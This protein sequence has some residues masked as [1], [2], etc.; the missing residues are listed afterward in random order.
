ML[1]LKYMVPITYLLFIVVTVTKIHKFVLS[2]TV[3]ST[4]ILFLIIINKP[5]LAPLAFS[6]LAGQIVII[7][8][9]LRALKV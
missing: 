9:L 6:L 2:I 8:N 4:S 7:F 1:G 3:T 5:P